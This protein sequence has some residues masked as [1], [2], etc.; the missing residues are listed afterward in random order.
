MDKYADWIIT[1]MIIV[2]LVP[3]ILGPILLIGLL[4]A[5]LHLAEWWRRR[6]RKREERGGSSI[7]WENGP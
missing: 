7:R 4:E 1:F 2:S 5:A 6:S 3:A